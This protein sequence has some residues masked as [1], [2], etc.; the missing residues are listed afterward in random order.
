MG[1]AKLAA[2]FCPI[3]GIRAE[4]MMHMHGLQLEIQRCTQVHQQIK[5]HTG[6]EAATQRQQQGLARLYALD[7]KIFQSDS[8]I[9]AGFSLV[10]G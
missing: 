1:A 10:L 5:Q 4:A 3:V 9:S 6:I 2:K 7:E 8:K